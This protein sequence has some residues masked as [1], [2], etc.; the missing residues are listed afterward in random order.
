MPIIIAANES[1]KQ[2]LN[3]PSTQQEVIWANNAQQFLQYP[4]ADAY[5]DLLFDNTPECLSLLRSLSPKPVVVNSVIYTLTETHPSFVRINGWSTFLQT[6][7]VEASAANEQHKNNVAD[8]FQQ[9]NKQLEWLPDEPGF[10]TP[11]VISTI[12]NEAYFALSEG[13]STKEEI[14][15]AMKLGTNY[16]YGPFEW[17]EKIGLK[18]IA[19]LLHQL[20]KQQPLYEPCGLLVQEANDHQ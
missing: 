5:I 11:R 18:N 2:E 7:C 6:G 9:F 1:I 15:I 4:Q 19:A 10:V 12:V 8:V 20:S 17:S 16:P 3:L 14:D 13:V